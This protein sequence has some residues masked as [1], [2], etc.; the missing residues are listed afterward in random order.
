M[1]AAILTCGLAVT[2]LS[3]CS[4]DD[5]GKTET[6]T[7]VTMMYY[8]K[9][10]DDVMKVADVEVNY[11]DQT[12]A[13]KKETLTSAE[14][15]KKLNANALPLTEGIWA[16]ITPKAAVPAGNYQLKV[17]TAAGYQA[18][19]STFNIVTDAYGNNPDAA[20]TVAQTADEVAAWCAQSG[21]VAF[22]VSNEG[23]AKQTKVDFGG[24][25][26]DDEDWITSR[27]HIFSGIFGFNDD[28]C[29]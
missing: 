19:L 26:D 21:T 22:T 4:S 5:D 11:V 6:K 8:L 25:D 1:L 15:K 23:Y 17:T 20:P 13:K 12:G 2:A 7:E 14:W 10:T 9:V 27:C 18:K 16:K 28:L 24:N 3:A 29:K